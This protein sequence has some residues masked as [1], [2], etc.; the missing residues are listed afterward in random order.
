MCI[1]SETSPNKP[2]RMIGEHALTKVDI[3]SES[4]GE[5]MVR[6]AVNARTNIVKTRIDIIQKTRA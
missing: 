2:P 4:N 6:L 5:I 3:G 1:D